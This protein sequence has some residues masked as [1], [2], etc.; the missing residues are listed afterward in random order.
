MV[1]GLRTA[2]EILRDESLMHPEMSPFE[3]RKLQAVPGT[4]GKVVRISGGVLGAA[5]EFFKAIAFEQE[6][7]VQA[8]R[9]ALSEGLEG[10]ELHARIADIMKDPSDG[11]VALAQEHARYQTFTNQLGKTG[12][13]IQ[14]NPKQ[15][16]SKSAYAFRSDSNQY[17]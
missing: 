4:L 13:E 12:R 2:G 1:A 15:S 11:T 8:R 16:F 7:A 10:S 14:L 3:Q 17:L 5:D 9:T 6:L